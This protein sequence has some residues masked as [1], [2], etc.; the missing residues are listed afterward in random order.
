MTVGVPVE[1]VKKEIKT[2]IDTYRKE[3]KKVCAAE[4]SG[5]PADQL[6]QPKLL[7]YETA[8]A[9]LRPIIKIRS[10]LDNG[11]Q[12]EVGR[13]EGS[14]ISCRKVGRKKVNFD[15]FLTQQLY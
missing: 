7:W 9:F 13:H 12:N 3:R 10:T 2:V 4:R 11:I 8:D 6:Y 15:L 5:I 14:A 1:D